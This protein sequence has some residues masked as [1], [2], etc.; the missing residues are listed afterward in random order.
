M[1]PKR[2]HLKTQTNEKYLS[3]ALTATYKAKSIL[4]GAANTYIADTE[5]YPPGDVSICCKHLKEIKLLWGIK[6]HMK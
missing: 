5:E 4:F 1:S 3:E 2:D 6:V